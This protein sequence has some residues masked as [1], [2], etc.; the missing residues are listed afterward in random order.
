MYGLKRC[1]NVLCLFHPVTRF[2][3][4]AKTDR[5]RTRLF[6]LTSA[7]SKVWNTLICFR[8]KNTPFRKLNSNQTFEFM[9]F[10]CHW[11]KC[12]WGDFLPDRS[13][14]RISGQ[15]WRHFVEA[16]CCFFCLV[17]LHSVVI[18]P[19]FLGPLQPCLYH[20]EV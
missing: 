15:R 14:G 10:C 1:F 16:N 9:M 18:L 19:F 3:H 13:A 8:Y 5:G 2:P 11:F 6:A 20:Q 12:Y 17:L 4:P 7:G